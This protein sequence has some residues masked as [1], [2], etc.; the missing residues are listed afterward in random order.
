[1]ATSGKC[2]DGPCGPC[3]LCTSHSTKYSHSKRFNSE[4]YAFLCRLEEQEIDKTCYPCYKQTQINVHNTE[5]KP[6]WQK[7]SNIKNKIRCGIENAAIREYIEH[8]LRSASD[9]IHSSSRCRYFCTIMSDTLQSGIHSAQSVIFL[10]ILWG[11]TKKR[12]AIQ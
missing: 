12:W 1:M 6:W 2:H 4:V 5:F 3:F 9:L 8:I 7:E 11:Q 10:W